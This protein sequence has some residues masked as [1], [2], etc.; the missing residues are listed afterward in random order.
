MRKKASSL[1]LHCHF[2]RFWLRADIC[3]SMF[4][5]KENIEKNEVSVCWCVY[6]CAWVCMSKRASFAWLAE[7]EKQCKHARASS[8]VSLIYSSPQF[9][10]LNSLI[11]YSSSSSSSSFSSSSALCLLA[12]FTRSFAFVFV[13]SFLFLFFFSYLFVLNW[14]T[15]VWIELFVCYLLPKERFVYLSLYSY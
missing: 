14:M 1:F 11:W 9:V 3:S 5:A 7:E 8:T 12:C 6:M 15:F 4:T 2:D 10:C 13:R